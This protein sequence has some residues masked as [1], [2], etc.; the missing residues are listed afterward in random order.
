MLTD[1]RLRSLSPIRV[2]DG[3][4]NHYAPIAEA[5]LGETPVSGQGL[6][7]YANIETPQGVI[8]FA[9]PKNDEEFA[10]VL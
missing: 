8:R 1:F 4:E 3:L 6:I 2:S 7:A 5:L 9:S 10:Q